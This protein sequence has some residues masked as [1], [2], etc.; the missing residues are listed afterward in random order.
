MSDQKPQ[1]IFAAV[2]EENGILE[3]C[4]PA[5]DLADAFAAYAKEIG[6]DLD[7]LADGIDW[8]VVPASARWCEYSGDMNDELWDDFEERRTW[9][10]NIYA[11]QGYDEAIARAETPLASELYEDGLEVLKAETEIVLKVEYSTGG[12]E[13][14][15]VV[16]VYPH[17]SKW[18][19]ATAAEVL[20]A[21]RAGSVFAWREACPTT[22]HMAWGERGGW[23]ASRE[24]VAQAIAQAAQR[25]DA[26]FTTRNVGE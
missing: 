22:E 11:E 5:F 12:S 7:A 2:S 1:T 21:A 18:G 19:I 15:W 20:D 26:D 16:V 13:R 4:G 8:Y 3:F 24:A 6:V 14:V 9:I 25:L 17:G 23:Y 10:N